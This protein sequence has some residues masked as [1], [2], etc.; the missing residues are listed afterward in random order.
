[1]SKWERD[2]S[3][4]SRSKKIPVGPLTLTS[5][6]ANTGAQY[7]SSLR[8][9]RLH[10]HPPLNIHKPIK[11][12]AETT[13]PRQKSHLGVMAGRSPSHSQ[14]FSFEQLTAPCSHMISRRK[15]VGYDFL[16]LKQPFHI[17]S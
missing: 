1:M 6:F 15:R 11:I 14:H 13:A 17:F 16:K 3:P 12:E 5:R 4:V 10:T 7:H 9:R 8:A 2:L